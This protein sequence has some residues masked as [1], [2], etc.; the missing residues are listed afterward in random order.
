MHVRK[1]PDCG[2]EFR[3]E[4]VRCS[5]CGATLVDHWEEEG[6]GGERPEPGHEAEIPPNMLM[7]TEHRPI[8]S[9]PSAAEIEPM[10]RRLG[11]AGIPFAVT[12][13]VHMFLLLVPEVDVERA[14][15]LLAGTAGPAEPEEPVE[16]SPVCPACGADARGAS[17]CPECGLALLA[18]PESLVRSG[19]EP[20]E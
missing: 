10:A 7:P 19:R 2:E 3:P 5:D 1:C 8:A 12:G 4:I 13:S 14:M 18:D 11:E 17:E 9:A 6:G 16:A 15:A 20:V